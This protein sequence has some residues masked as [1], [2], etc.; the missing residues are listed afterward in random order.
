LKVPG[1]VHLLYFATFHQ[2]K[3]M[4][5]EPGFKWQ[6]KIHMQIED[7]GRS[8]GMRRVKVPQAKYPHTG[9]SFF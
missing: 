5:Q 2:K 3:W 9:F 6:T 4:E 8:K 7:V 1:K